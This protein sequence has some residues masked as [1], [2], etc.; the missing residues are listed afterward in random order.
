MRMDA[1]TAMVEPGEAAVRAVA[2]GIDVVLD[3]PDPVAAFRGIRAA[4]D[5]GRLSRAQVTASVRRILTAKARLGLHRMR[6][7]NLE[8]VPLHVGGRRH[9]AVAREVAEKALTLVKDERN[10]VPLT[11]PGDASV[12]YLSVL[13]YP[14]NWRTAAPSRTMIP[15][16][17][18]RWPDV[19]AVEI[20][21]RASPGE[22]ALL[23]A[24]ASRYDAVIAGVYVRAASASGRLDLAPQV[25]GLL[26]DIARTTAR[27][28][29][30]MAAV[31][32]GNPYASMSLPDLPAVL[33]AYD[34]SDH[35]E[36]AAVRALAGEAPITGTL[37]IALPG[38]FPVGHG[39]VR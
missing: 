21:D 23:R 17:R 2:A 8:S 26:D 9:E 20:S 34:F 10:M 33:L 13:D 35:A 31:F 37:P 14:S 12:L 19:E 39:L 32:F 27:R 11:L 4:I 29:T 24:M 1:I 5:S 38:L 16:L 28:G 15:E 22:I 6:G 30:P 25:V 3:S 7:V 18:A 36:R